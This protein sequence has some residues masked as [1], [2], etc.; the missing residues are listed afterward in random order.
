MKF[1][2]TKQVELVL[3]DTEEFDDYL[4]YFGAGDN[5]KYLEMTRKCKEIIVAQF[6]GWDIMNI[7]GSRFTHIFVEMRKEIEV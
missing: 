7:T 2:E 5:N 3:D 6:P 4:F 1:Y